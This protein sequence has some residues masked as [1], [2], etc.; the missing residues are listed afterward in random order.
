M[1][2]IDQLVAQA[3]QYHQAGALPQAEQ[4]YRQ[5]LQ[6]DPD[7]ADALHLLGVLAN[8]TGQYDQAIAYI[9]KALV[10]CP[11]EAA[12]YANL[13]L[14]YLAQGNLD[15]TVACCKEALRLQP[16]FAEVRNT[17]GL[18]L[19]GQGKRD[20]ALAC[21]EQSLRLK[22]HYAQPHFNLGTLRRDQGNLDAAVAHF[23]Q[24]ARFQPDYAEAHRHLGAALQTQRKLDEAVACYRRVLQLQPNDVQTLSN[25]GNALLD[26]GKT[27]EAVASYRQALALRPDYAEAHNNLGSAL[28]VQG[29]LDEAGA[30][31]RQ[32]LRLRPDLAVAHNNLGTLLEEQGDLDGALA[33]YQQ[34]LRFD[35]EHAGARLNCAR[36]TLLQGRFTQG[37]PEYECRFKHADALQRTFPQP[38]WDGAPL[39]GKTILLYAEQGLGDTLQ[40]IRYAALANRSGGRV[41]VQCQ[42]PVLHLVSRCPGVDSVVTTGA[43]LPEFDVQAPLM[44]LPGILETTLDN[45]PADVPYLSADAQRIDY[46]RQQLSAQPGYRVG[47]VWQGNPRN[48]SDR[49]R[50]V[51]LA[52]LSPLT[53]IAG[54]RLFSLQVGPGAEQLAASTAPQ[55]VTDLGSR[56]DPQSFEDAAAILMVLDLVITVDTAAA[57]LGG[58]LGVPVWVMLPVVP[59]WRWLL[60]REDSP[61]Y[62]TLR[63]FRQTRPGDWGTVFHRMGLELRNLIAS[64]S[65]PLP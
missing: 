64:R 8:Q 48:K 7:N 20:E 61:W 44:S 33:S 13:A 12:F 23:R 27:D 62:P 25:L 42:A 16:D 32:A 14:P 60:Q 54:V 55:G 29:K 58:G 41:I 18:A 1:N 43:P 57:H 30:S 63:L 3:L 40:F 19:Q 31:Y 51:P 52:Q 50:S 28:C 5:I 47:I 9:Q 4:L 39:S 17:L 65:A 45:M 10:R 38:R 26:Q 59:D 15:Q 2:S 6:A 56:L 46:W 36:L 53:E 11:R 35:P 21:Y 24:A 22:P 49:F 34:T 37:W